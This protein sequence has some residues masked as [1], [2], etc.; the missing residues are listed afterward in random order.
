MFHFSSRQR[1][2]VSITTKTRRLVS[3]RSNSSIRSDCKWRHAERSMEWTR[4]FL[5]RP[6]TMV[7]SS[8][9]FQKNK[10]K[11]SSFRSTAAKYYEQ[12]GNNAQAFQCY[13]LTEDYAALEKL[14]QSLQ[15]NDPLLRVKSV[16]KSIEICLIFVVI[17]QSA[18]HSQESAYASQRLTLI[19]E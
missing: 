4:R 8:N 1:F 3:C 13:A 14:S 5:F 12:C 15:E 7:S 9:F 11:R 6:T 18:I 16:L 10:K 2:S 17:R 19:N